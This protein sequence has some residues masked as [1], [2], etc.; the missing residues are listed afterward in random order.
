MVSEPRFVEQRGTDRR[1]DPHNYD[2]LAPVGNI[3][4]A[5]YDLP[6]LSTPPGQSVWENGL[7]SSFTA[8]KMLK[9]TRRPVYGEPSGQEGGRKGLPVRSTDAMVGLAAVAAVTKLV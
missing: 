4:T 2:E 9:Q 8:P 7:P 5:L 3:A 1:C 6:A